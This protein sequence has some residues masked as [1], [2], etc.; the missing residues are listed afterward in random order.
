LLALFSSAT[1]AVETALRIQRDALRASRGRPEEEQLRVRAALDAVPLE[2]AAPDAAAVGGLLYRA[3]ALAD[4][5]GAGQLLGARGGAGVEPGTAS[6]HRERARAARAGA[7]RA[8]VFLAALG[9]LGALVGGALLFSGALSAR[10]TPRALRQHL[11]APAARAPRP[12]QDPAA[13]AEI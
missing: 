13:F 2:G 5:A 1:T 9:V 4:A 11:A 8:G 7:R 3:G 6:L 12:R 10:S